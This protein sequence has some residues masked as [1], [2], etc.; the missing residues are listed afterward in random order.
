MVDHWKKVGP[1][2]Y[3]LVTN[4]LPFGRN[5][6]TIG[7]KWSTIGKWSD[8]WKM[9]D[10]MVTNWS[11]QWS[12]FWQMVDHL[13]KWST[14]LLPT[15][16]KNG[17]PFNGRQWKSRPFQWSTIWQNADHWMVDHCKMVDHWAELVDHCKWSTIGRVGI[18]LDGRPFDQRSDHWLLQKP[19]SG[20]DSGHD[21]EALGKQRD[22]VRIKQN[23]CKFILK[24]KVIW[25]IIFYI[26][27]YHV[28]N[29]W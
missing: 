12:A 13:A 2:G 21:R 1:N 24:R 18:L 11:D 26:C 27:V 9:V 10:Q 14:I 22:A 4:W 17:R 16:T 29:L 19:K 15:T 5:G 6:P 23:H 8:L 7:L 25:E 20:S 28:I 3:Q